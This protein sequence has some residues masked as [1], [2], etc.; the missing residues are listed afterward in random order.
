L[1]GVGLSWHMIKFDWLAVIVCRTW[2]RQRCSSNLFLQIRC[3]ICKNLPAN[4]KQAPVV[5]YISQTLLLICRKSGYGWLRKCTVNMYKSTYLIVLNNRSEPINNS[6]DYIT[7]N[8]TVPRI[9]TV[10]PYINGPSWVGP[11][12]AEQFKRF[13]K[14]PCQVQR[15]NDYK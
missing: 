10:G 2:K 8:E 3:D 4:G 15:V 6:F 7:T 1:G 9:E 14:G 5:K 13:E 12:L 11:A